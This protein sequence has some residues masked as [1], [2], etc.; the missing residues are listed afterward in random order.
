[1]VTLW[2]QARWIDDPTVTSPCLSVTWTSN[3]NS[4][5]ETIVRIEV[6][7]GVS[8]EGAPFALFAPTASQI[9]MGAYAEGVVG[10]GN[11]IVLFDLPA[12]EYRLVIYP[13]GQDPLEL[14]LAV[15]EES[16]VLTLQVDDPSGT[17]DPTTEPTGTATTEPTATSPGENPTATPTEVSTVAALPATG[18]GQS[19]FSGFGLASMLAAGMMLVV[20]SVGI[21]RQT[22][23]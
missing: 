22:R 1:G 23:P 19:G 15:S 6:P 7:E 12:G 11:T 9:A 18:T 10:P 17:P 21:R 4:V 20:M 5:T 8:L 3:P 13:E 16:E 2:Y 14:P